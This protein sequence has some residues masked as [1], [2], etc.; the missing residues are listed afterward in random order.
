M[1]AGA[2]PLLLNTARAFAEDS[3]TLSV[4]FLALKQLAANDESVKLVGLSMCVCS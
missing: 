1:S 2:I 3:S 4:V